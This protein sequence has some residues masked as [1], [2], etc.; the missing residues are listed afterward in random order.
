MMMLI[1]LMSVLR[2]RSVDRLLILLVI[3]FGGVVWLLTGE[4]ALCEWH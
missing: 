2:L 3:R 1:F 4:R